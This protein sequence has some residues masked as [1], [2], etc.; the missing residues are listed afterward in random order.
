MYTQ[1]QE[2]KHILDFFKNRNTPGVLVDIGANDGKT[3]SNSL[4]LIELGWR[5]ILI[6]PSYDCVQMLKEL[7]EDNFNVGILRLAISNTPGTVKFHESGPLVVPELAD[8]VNTSLVSTLVESE[9]DRWKSLQMDWKET[10]VN[11]VK[12]DTI[13]A[14]AGDTFNFI[15]IDAEGMDI[16]ILKQIDLSKIELLCIEWNSKP[17]VKAEILEYTSKFGMN[18]IIYENG[19]NILISHK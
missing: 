7:H 13:T 2:E 8:T 4:R 14:H 19:E 16:E 11:A 18:N 1:G 9:K 17:E 12:W 3:Y 6:E 5:A 10:E 15:S